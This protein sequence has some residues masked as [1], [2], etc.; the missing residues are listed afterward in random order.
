MKKSSYNN[1]S[2]KRLLGPIMLGFTALIL[3][4]GLMHIFHMRFNSGDVYPAYSS[5]KA[6][7]LG[8][9]ALYE[10]I[11]AMQDMS[12]IRR[13][14]DTGLDSIG[15][16][17]TLLMIAYD[18]FFGFNSDL[19]SSD[20]TGELKRFFHSSGRLAMSLPP[21]GPV[22]PDIKAE[23]IKKKEED[24]KAET[25]STSVITNAAPTIKSW[26][27]LTNWLG[28]AVTYCDHVATNAELADVSLTGLPVQMTLLTSGCFTN[29]ANEWKVIYRTAQGPVVIEKKIGNGS[30]ALCSS[31][32][33]LSN[34]SLSK[35]RIS[36][37]I[38][39]FIGDNKKMIFD[40][41]HLGISTDRGVSFLA[42][43]YRLYWLLGG[44]VLLAALFIW[45]N[46]CPLLPA[47][48]ESSAATHEENIS[49]GKDSAS[50][51]AN[52][53]RQNIST[54]AVLTTCFNEWKKDAAGNG[55]ISPELISTI[56]K[57][58]EDESHRP[59]NHKDPV[60][61]YNAITQMLEDSR[62]KHQ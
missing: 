45:K 41:T 51:L 38:A 54:S 13:V 34:E 35:E 42:R 58:I 25:N 21:A 56:Y 23:R 22:H 62:R 27:A 61:V 7:P 40:E 24:K 43:K 2:G 30:I 28:V 12:V 57:L 3:A 60:S 8:T 46:S 48:F 44:C 55:G 6:D 53:L 36:P 37:L 50:A 5:F 14:D 20:E 39:W 1:S 59:A 19:I 29:L 10:S 9:K 31:S 4:A 52:I 32:Y 26:L 17:N 33:F 15:P 16:S 11:G 49:H 47:P 18:G